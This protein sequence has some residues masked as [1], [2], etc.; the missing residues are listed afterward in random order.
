MMPSRRWAPPSPDDAE[1]LPPDDVFAAGERNHHLSNTAYPIAH[2]STWAPYRLTRAAHRAVVEDAWRAID[3]LCLYLHIPFCE[4][5]CAYCEYTVVNREESSQTDSYMDRLERELDLYA[6]LL[7]ATGQ[8]RRRLHGLDVG[9]GTPT[10]VAAERIAR[11]LERVHARFDRAPGYGVSI[12]TTPKIAAAE[13]AKLAALRQAGIDR[14]SLGVQVVQPDLLRVLNRADNGAALHH[15]AVDH[16]R[17][18]GFTRL[19]VDLMYGFADQSLDSW[20]ATVE[21]ALALAPEYVTLYRMR[22]KLTRISHQAARVALDEVR[23]QAALAKELLAA[24]GYGAWTGKNTWSRLP[25][26]HGT[27][28]YL[29][30]RVIDGMP[31]LGLG[32]G[33]QSF[34]HTTIAYN[35]GAVG[36]NLGPYLRSVDAGRLP[37]QDLYDL[38]LT[39]MAAKFVAVSFYFGGIDAAAFAAK[40]GRTLAEVFPAELAFV[41]REGLMRWEPDGRLQL[42]ERGAARTHGVIALFFAPSVQRHLVELKEPAGDEL[43]DARQRPRRPHLARAGLA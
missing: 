24:A 5:R 7:G 14:I 22:Y 23:A 2:G 19:N 32:L 26:D 34:S 25:D 37:I 8:A 11:L 10:F 18:A 21:H 16:L 20:R 28:A 36:K 35:D 31:Y 43:V 1:R 6:D 40:F 13:P 30:R 41:E 29:T 27:S 39:Q 42:T 9:G 12:E 17:A 15:R 38:P 4:T 3:D 33:A